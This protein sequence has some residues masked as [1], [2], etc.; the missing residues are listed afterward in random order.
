MS[1]LPHSVRTA[2]FQ[3]FDV[4]IVVHHLST[5]E[6][7]VEEASLRAL[8]DA[9]ANGCVDTIDEDVLDEAIR[10]IFGTETSPTR[11]AGQA[12]A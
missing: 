12:A 4:D 8:I 5:G 6:R 10:E 2:T 7:V 9:L 11:H 3:L 1:D